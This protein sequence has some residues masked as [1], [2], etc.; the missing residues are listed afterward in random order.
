MS[1]GYDI[2]SRNTSRVIRW[3]QIVQLTDTTF[4][5]TSGMYADF[6]ALQKM[7]EVSLNTYEFKMGRQPTV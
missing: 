3:F 1:Q 7:L 5:G 6:K 2:I 4:L